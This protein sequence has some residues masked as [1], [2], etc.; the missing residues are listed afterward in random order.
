MRI[1]AFIPVFIFPFILR[2][3]VIKTTG[4]NPDINYERLAKIDN[5]VND[6]INKDWLK[7]AVTIVVKDNQVVQLKAY[8][9][10]DVALKT[11]VVYASLK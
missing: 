1:I 8:G 9:Y 4:S 11:P 6:Y 5:L 3:Q 2:A 10:A 7:G